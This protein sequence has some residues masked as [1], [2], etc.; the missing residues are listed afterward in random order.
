M[1][2]HEQNGVASLFKSLDVASPGI[3][4]DVLRPRFQVFG[5]ETLEIVRAARAMT[6]HYNDVTDTRRTS[7]AHSRV[8]LIGVQFAALLIKWMTGGNLLPRLNTRDTF[9]ITE[10]HDP[11]VALS[12]FILFSLLLFFC[13]FLQ[14]ANHI[15]CKPFSRF[16]NLSTRKELPRQ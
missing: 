8:H 9:H 1:C 11:H 13:Y 7:A 14:R 6:I 4:E 12:P 2:A 15:R 5:Q 16:S 10:N 3:A